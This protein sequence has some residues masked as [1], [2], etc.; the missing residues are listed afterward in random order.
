VDKDTCAVVVSKNKISLNDLYVPHKND[1]G[2][3]LMTSFSY[4]WNPDVGSTCSYLW[5]DTYMCVGVA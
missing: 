1:T 5:L 4:K 2:A 3:P